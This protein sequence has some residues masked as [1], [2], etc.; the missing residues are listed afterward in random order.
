M[1]FH[2]LEKVLARAATNR[3]FRDELASGDADFDELGLNDDEQSVLSELVASSGAGLDAVLNIVTAIPASAAATPH[4][5]MQVP[6]GQHPMAGAT[7]GNGLPA[8]AAPMASPATTTPAFAL[9]TPTMTT[10]PATMPP[11]AYHPGPMATPGGQ[12]QYTHVTPPSPVGSPGVPM[13]YGAPPA[14]TQQGGTNPTAASYSNPAATN[15]SGAPCTP[16][17]SLDA[18]D[19]GRP[20]VARLPYG[21]DVVK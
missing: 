15:G 18:S 16:H 13:G 12:P 7:Q 9:M 17:R 21:M 3:A 2:Q 11:A 5:T 1:A 8:G 20:V 4:A 6:A 14:Y 10:P 19:L